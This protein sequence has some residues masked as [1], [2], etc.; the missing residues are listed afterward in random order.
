MSDDATTTLPR[1]KPNI[2]WWLG[3]IFFLLLMLFSLQLFGPNPPVLVSTQTTYITEPVGPDGLPDYEKY[4]LE[5]YREGVTPENNAAALIWK[6]LWPGELDPSH[7]A[8]VA[9]ELGLDEIPLREDSLKPVHRHAPQVNDW[10]K[11]QGLALQSDELAEEIISRAGSRAWTSDQIP[12]LVDWIQDNR[13]P[14]DLLIEASRRPRCYFPSPSLLDDQSEGIYFVLLPGVQG[15]REA[16][17]ALPVRA[18]WH[19]GEGRRQ[20]AWQDLLATHRI[21]RLVAQG[22]T[23]VEILVGIAIDSIATS[24]TLAL[25]GDERLSVEEARQIRSDLASLPPFKNMTSSLNSTERIGTLDAVVRSS[26]QGL[27]ALEE[28][29]SFNSASEGSPLTPLLN[30]LAVDWNEVLRDVNVWYDRIAAAMREPNRETREA[31]IDQLIRTLHQRE[32]KLRQPTSLAAGVISRA[33]R[34]KIV[35]GAVISMLTPAF[36]AA[37]A[38]EDRTNAKL[39]LLQLA[40]PLAVYRAEHGQYPEK[41]EDLV[42]GILGKLPVDSFKSK[43]FLYRR[44]DDG[45]LLYSLGA[46]GIDD[47]GSNEQQNL[48]HGRL[49]EDIDDLQEREELREKIPAGSDD[50]AIRMPRSVF[51]LPTPETD[52]SANEF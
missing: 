23:M 9:R 2:L 25:L 44:T 29:A 11:K 45:Y 20:E 43:A 21:G 36:Q 5:R 4:L 24:G 30:T 10:L 47:G 32:Q 14:L 28:L 6:A 46:N 51:T 22:E 33:E 39:E 42:P 13:E 7:Y 1:Q 49:L 35:A 18:M 16:G 26:R 41:L 40:A 37:T 34:S 31:A 15:A 27:G 17:R 12:P 52:S 38:A 19:L 48:F 50:P 3:G 8:A